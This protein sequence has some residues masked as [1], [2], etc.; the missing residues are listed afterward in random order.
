MCKQRPVHTVLLPA[1]VLCIASLAS[2]SEQ[3][4][5]FASGQGT[6]QYTV[7]VWS[8]HCGPMGAYNW[9]EWNYNNLVYINP[10]AS[11]V[12]L[13]GGGTYYSSPG[14]QYG[15]PPSGPQPAQ[16]NYGDAASGFLINWHPGAGQVS[17]GIQFFGSV[18]PSYE[19]AAVYYAPPGHLSYADYSQT[20]MVG[21]STDISSSFESSVSKSVTLGYSGSSIFGTGSKSNTAGSTF[22]QQQDSS[23]SIDVS[24]NKTQ[25]YKIY[26]PANDALGLY[27]PDDEVAVWLNPVANLLLSG[28]AVG[29]TSD[30]WDGRDPAGNIEVV[31]PSCYE[32]QNPS[33]MPPQLAGYM[34]KT[35]DPSGGLGDSDFA[36]IALHNPYC[37]ASPPVD[38]TRYQGPING[39]TIPYVEPGSPNQQ[40]STWY[41]TTAYSVT[42]TQGQAAQYTYSLNFGVTYKYSSFND[43]LTEDLA[44]SGTWKWTNKWSSTETSKVTQN[45]TVSITSPAY[46]SGYT[47]PGEFNMYQDNIYGTYMFYAAQ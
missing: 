32:L 24:Y 27:H 36:A 45:A 46:G 20:T 19:V 23:S 44:A 41:W 1:L 13:G 29:W 6:I 47:G 2:A 7:T 12:E 8:G 26:G 15:C 31:Y 22:T 16:I 14:V 38:A 30:S 40:P 33:N 5:N 10:P 3:Y 21:A 28:G 4:Y 34:Q 18:N 35:W 11:D 37:N 39:S 9:T 42:N 43:L 17:A 25:G